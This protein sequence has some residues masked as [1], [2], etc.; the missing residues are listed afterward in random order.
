MARLIVNAVAAEVV[1]SDVVGDVVI[2]VSVSRADD[3]SP[4]TGL[5][6]DNFRLA[7]S[8]GF[9]IDTVVS[10]V[11]ESKWEP[12]DKEPSGCYELWIARTDKANLVQ[13]WSKGEYYQFGVQVR[14]FK[15]TSVVDCG[16]TVV[17]VQSLGT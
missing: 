2:Y 7:S 17:N 3:G 10:Q 9:A 15:I 14:T 12:E 4:V 5:T 6:K 8:V 11:N 1:G 13:K 16:Q